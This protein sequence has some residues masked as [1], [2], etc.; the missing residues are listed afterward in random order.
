MGY[1]TVCFLLEKRFLFGVAFQQKIFKCE[2]LSLK[3][4]VMA[5]VW[6]QER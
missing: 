3:G 6:P 4:F 2:S 1:S 5:D